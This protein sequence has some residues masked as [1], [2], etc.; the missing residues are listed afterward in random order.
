MISDLQLSLIG[1]FKVLITVA[2]P[3]YWL[4]AGLCVQYDY[5]IYIEILHRAGDKD[6]MSKLKSIPLS[7]HVIFVLFYGQEGLNRI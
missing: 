6:H 3:L 4:V 7:Y 1:L 2:C 5:S